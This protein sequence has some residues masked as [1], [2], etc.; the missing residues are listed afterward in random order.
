MRIAFFRRFRD[1]CQHPA[2][3]FRKPSDQ[4]GPAKLSEFRQSMK[5]F[6]KLGI[7][8]QPAITIC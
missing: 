4:H 6:I 1:R 8:N 2:F 7:S 3:Q 5:K